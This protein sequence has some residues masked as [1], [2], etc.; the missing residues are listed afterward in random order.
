MRRI[1]AISMAAAIPAVL[2][3]HAADARTK[4]APQPAG[5]HSRT[6]PRTGHG[7]HG[8]P[9]HTPVGDNNAPN[10]RPGTN[11]ANDVQVSADDGGN[12][13]DSHNT[14]TANGAPATNGAPE[15]HNA[16]QA[17]AVHRGRHTGRH[18]RTT[19]R[20]RTQGPA[21]TRPSTGADTGFWV[22]SDADTAMPAEAAEAIR[23]F[24][25][26][27]GARAPQGP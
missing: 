2:P 3:V 19:P 8:R 16:P 18:T 11:P 22:P 1:L 27:L 15:A 5:T 12:E 24:G 14:P 13:D 21:Q 6:A 25:S 4:P 23:E 7:A 20:T 9:A 17:P 26:M 10:G